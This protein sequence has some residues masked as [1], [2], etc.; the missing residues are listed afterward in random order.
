MAG[1]SPSKS[2][3]AALIYGVAS[4]GL[5]LGV[6]VYAVGFIGGFATPTRID[7]VPGRPL[8]QALAIDL[9]MTI[10]GIDI[11][12]PKELKG[13]LGFDAT[14]LKIAGG[15]DIPYVTPAHRNIQEP[16]VYADIA[17]L[18]DCILENQDPIPTAE[19]ARHVV[20]VIEAG[21]RA[22]ETGVAQEIRSTL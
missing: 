14:S 3:L 7:G 4:Y 19:H 18:A 8:S 12:A 6:F 17:H 2:G 16:H 21:Y 20:E 15:R 5:F 13:T 10:G 9:G 1:S 22:A 11:N